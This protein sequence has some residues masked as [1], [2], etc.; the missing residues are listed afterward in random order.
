MDKR[1]LG[2][3]RASYR[4]PGTVFALQMKLGGT[5]LQWNRFV[6]S[7]GSTVPSPESLDTIRLHLLTKTKLGLPAL[8]AKN[9]HFVTVYF[10][11]CALTDVEAEFLMPQKLWGANKILHHL[12][13]KT[14]TKELLQQRQWPESK[15]ISLRTFASANP[16]TLSVVC[17]LLQLAAKLIVS[18]IFITFSDKPNIFSTQLQQK[19]EN[20]NT[21]LITPCS[22]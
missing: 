11:P 6:P 4:V 10:I 14:K 5:W 20:L 8:A 22:K 16:M 13:M 3:E 7:R 15:C 19:I 17:R 21:R 12:Q 2:D 9:C 18:A 1:W